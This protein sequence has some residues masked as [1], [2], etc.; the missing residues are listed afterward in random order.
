MIYLLLGQDTAA[1]DAQITQLKK[2]ILP[3]PDAIQFDCESLEAGSMGADELKKALISLPA[4]APQRLIVIRESHR[5][6]AHQQQIIKEWVD[7]STPHAVLVLDSNVWDFNDEFV[8]KIKKAKII[9][10]PGAKNPGVFDMMRAMER[11][12]EIE[13]LKILNQLFSSGIH[14]LQIMGGLVWWWSQLRRKIP[15]GRF[16]NGILSLQETDFNIK[17]SRLKPEYALEMLVVKLC[18]CLVTR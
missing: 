12:N 9:N 18:L 13:A 15:S 10:F 3:S 5:L 6:T 2:N 14:P 11:H 7:N 16:E 17:R 8:K 4:I 1:K